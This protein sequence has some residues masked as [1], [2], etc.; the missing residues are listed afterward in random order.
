MSGEGGEDV[1][2]FLVGAGGVGGC[3]ADEFGEGW[4]VVFAEI[5][6]VV[7]RCASAVAVGVVEVAAFEGDGAEDGVDGDG[8]V[9]VDCFAGEWRGVVGDELAVVE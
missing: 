1:G 9:L 5:E 3:V 6:G 8:A 2:G 7:E 4:G